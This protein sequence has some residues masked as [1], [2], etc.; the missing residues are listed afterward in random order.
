VT[1]KGRF[2]ALARSSKVLDGLMNTLEDFLLQ[3]K[4]HI[5]KRWLNLI[6][7]TYPADTQRFLKHQKNEFL[8]PVG[9]TIAKE[10]DILFS[11]LVKG[12]DSERTSASLDRI[13]RIRAIQDFSPS[14]AVSFI[15]LIK[16]V[17]RE[18]ILKD[19][20]EHQ[21]S[22]QLLALESRLDEMALLAFDIYVKCREKMY[23]IR[24]NEAKKQ[25]SGLLRR[26]G[27]LCDVPEWDDGPDKH[28][29]T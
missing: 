26:M 1:G 2:F 16:K 29:V 19:H 20:P 21:V 9:S 22:D 7:E 3:K 23:E 25:V 5:L 11:D 13:I 10:I 28:K 4:S 6:L 8:N 24:A 12:I 15:Y 17:V 27:L 14:K 18:E